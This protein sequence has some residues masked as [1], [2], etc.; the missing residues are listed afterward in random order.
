MGSDYFQFLHLTGNDP[1]PDAASPPAHTIRDANLNSL[2]CVL[3]LMVIGPGPSQRSKPSL[4]P[5][6]A[7]ISLFI[8]LF[9][10]LFIYFRVTASLA[11]DIDRHFN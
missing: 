8:Y 11:N 3:W 1:V 10:C 6:C 5:P 9:M 7:A 2:K 4:V